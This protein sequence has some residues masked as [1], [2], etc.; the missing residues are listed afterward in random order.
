MRSQVLKIIKMTNILITIASSKSVSFISPIF[1]SIT[2]IVL[3]NKVICRTIS[4]I[5]TETAC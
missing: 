4:V 2:K 1:D 3:Y 5:D